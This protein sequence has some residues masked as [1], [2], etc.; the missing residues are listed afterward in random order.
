MGRTGAAVVATALTLLTLLA[1]GVSAYFARPGRRT[2]VMV[3]FAVHVIVP[4]FAVVFTLSSTGFVV[5]A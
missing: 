2:K 3:L 5:P 4:L 1:L